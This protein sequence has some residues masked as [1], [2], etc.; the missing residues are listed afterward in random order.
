MDYTYTKLY[1]GIIFGGDQ[2]KCHAA[3][4]SQ[5]FSSKSNFSHACSAFSFEMLYATSSLGKCLLLCKVS[6]KSV[7]GILRYL[8]ISTKTV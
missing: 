2:N 7:R 1:F 8:G 3:M 4:M 6:Q 5:C